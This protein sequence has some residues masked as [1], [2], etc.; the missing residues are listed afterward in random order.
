[1]CEGERTQSE[2]NGD[3]IPFDGEFEFGARKGGRAEGLVRACTYSALKWNER[4]SGFD[5]E[6]EKEGREQT[7]GSKCRSGFHC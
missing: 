5:G 2:G 6:S 7:E 3:L 1:M 4:A